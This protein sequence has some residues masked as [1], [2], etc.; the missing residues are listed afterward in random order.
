MSRGERIELLA[1]L[2]VDPDFLQHFETGLDLRRP[3]RSAIPARVLGQGR[4]STVF[5]LGDDTQALVFKRL[6]VFRSDDDAIRYE[7]LHRKYVRSLGER[8]RVRVLPSTTLRVHDASGSRIVVYIIQEQ[9]HEDA[10]GHQAI[11]RLCTPDIDR[12]L[13]LIL[14]E[15]AKVFDLNATHPGGQEIGFDARFSNWALV[16]FD[17]DRPCMTERMRLAYLDTSTPLMR[18]RGQE[19]FDTTP[20]IRGMP[21]LLPM[22]L[23]RSTLND[24]IARYYDFRS[25]VVDMLANFYSEGRPEL[26]PWL[27]DSVN[28]F[29]LAERADTHFRP[30]TV[31]EVVAHHRRDALSWR[32]YLAVRK[33]TRKLRL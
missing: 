27:T 5:T 2:H 24:L 23:R 12:L 10:I 19:Q 8:A 11:Y 17:P 25:V 4:V 20:F 30:L 1:N 15:T 21:A 3:G 7:A 16:G 22:F 14:Q 31:T 28:W 18:S 9:A 6:A 32:A 33:L 26:V 13:T 29:F